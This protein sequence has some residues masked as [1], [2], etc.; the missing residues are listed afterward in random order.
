MFDHEYF[1]KLHDY[2][3]I[4]Q[5]LVDEPTNSLQDIREAV[6][7][8][9]LTLDKYADKLQILQMV[10]ANQIHCIMRFVNLPMKY[11]FVPFR[12]PVRLSLGTLKCVLMS[13]GEQFKCARQVVF[14]CPNQC[15]NNLNRI[16]DGASSGTCSVCRGKLREHEHLRASVHCRTIQ[17]VESTSV[18]TP[19]Q[20]GYIYRTL[21]V[22]LTDELSNIKMDIGRDYILTGTY[23][24]FSQLFMAWNFTES[25]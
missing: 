2:H 24:V 13:F 25:E 10:Q 7:C 22:R 20:Y 19:I 15:E 8:A 9:L 21:S 18:S 17:V 12:H 5:I 14:Y 11:A 6:Y 1:V 4:I 3:S 23:D 16:F